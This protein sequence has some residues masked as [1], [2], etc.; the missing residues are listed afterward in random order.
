MSP[1]DFQNPAHYSPE[2]MPHY[3]PLGVHPH[4]I[5]VPG[6]FDEPVVQVCINSKWA[7]HLTAGI[8]RFLY[9]D[10][11][12]GTEE[13][14]DA[15]IESVRKV[16]V[17]LD[18][19]E[20][21]CTMSCCCNEPPPLT[22]ITE[23]GVFQ[24]SS[25]G[26]TTWVDDPARD[27]RNQAT[28]LPPQDVAPGDAR[29]AAANSAVAFFEAAQAKMSS[30][31]G[32]DVQISAIITII[33]GILL[34]LGI[35]TGGASL[36][37]LTAIGLAV[38]GL[39]AE[40][41]NADFDET[42]WQALTCVFACNMDT[43]GRVYPAHL[44]EI[45]HGAGDVFG[46]GTAGGKWLL[47]L[48]QAMGEAGINNAAAIP[49]ANT[50]SCDDCGCSTVWEWDLRDPIDNTVIEKVGTLGHWEQG[51]GWTADLQDDGREFRF[52]FIWGKP[53]EVDAVGFDYFDSAANFDQIRFAASPYTL[54]GLD[55]GEN[56]TDP[57]DYNEEHFGTN[58]L[59]SLPT[60]IICGCFAGTGNATKVLVLRKV[61]LYSTAPMFFGTG[62]RGST[63]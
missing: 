4:D 40:Q 14:I 25:D 24:S 60:A 2:L 17:A 29:C 37:L 9:R 50:R 32:T 18:K 31:L 16:L 1:K 27:P 8:E 48:L 26:G 12:R 43:K 54:A 47:G 62:R 36:I 58:P 13:E 6:V 52:N 63:P 28:S 59:S 57:A 15:A 49:S 39:T 53:I 19:A 3:D 30:E 35:V 56:V 42:K 33:T 61:R 7:S 44:V 41:F 21:K 38:L 51:V 22:R 34:L 55:T 20:G 10:A 23:D 46:T 45:M 11:W 5:P